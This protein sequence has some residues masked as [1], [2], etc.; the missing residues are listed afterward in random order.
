[1]N[2]LFYFLFVFIF[3]FSQAKAQQFNGYAVP[4][5][6]SC[7]PENSCPRNAIFHETNFRFDKLGL[8]WNSINWDH[9]LLCR[10]RFLVSIRLGINYFSFSKINSAGAPIEL[11]LMIGEGPFMGEISAGLNYLYVYKNYNDSSQTKYNDNISYL[12]ATGRI[13]IRYQK[14]KSI[15]FRAGYTPMLSLIGYKKIPIIADKTFHSFYGAA[16]GYTF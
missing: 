6:K 1:M 3:F 16:I 7:A 8:N 9:N 10:E 12:G 11:N 14:K 4:R 15:F 2:K 13:G 5:A